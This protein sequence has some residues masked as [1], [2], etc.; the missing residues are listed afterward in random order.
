[1]NPFKYSLSVSQLSHVLGA[2]QLFAWGSL[3]YSFPLIAIAMEN[4]LGWSKSEIYMGASLGML[5]SSA[6]AYPIGLAID[7]GFGRWI[8]TIA[9]F[10]AALMLLIWSTVST[11][12]GF[13]AIS[14]V[15]GAL[16]ACTLY[17]AAFAVISNVAQREHSRSHITVITLW[18]GFASSVLI[19]LEQFFIN[20]IGWRS[21]LSCLGLMNIGW[22]II[23]FYTLKNVSNDS[24]I[25]NDPSELSRKIENQEAVKKAI[26]SSV[27]WLILTALTL[28]SVMFTV[29]IFHAFPILQEKGLSSTDAVKVLMVLG[30]IQVLGRLLLSYFAAKVPIRLIGSIFALFFPLIFIAMFYLK[31]SNFYFLLFLVGCYGLSNGIFTIVRSLVV[32]EM[33]S[34]NAYGAINGL[35]TI[36]TMIARAVGP[37]V[38]ASLWMIH[39]SY[40][41]VLILVIVVS[42]IFMI[43]FWTAS[44]IFS[45]TD[46]NLA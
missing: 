36:P 11:L 8:L 29:F 23:Y 30:P 26:R 18:G 27:F 31:T 20:E 37:G 38:A 10:F 25:K 32:P 45:Q 4:D 19:P 17:E 5:V 16:Q 3:Y 6:L 41:D 44:W 40:Q 46:N 22:A 14:I 7:N 34:R 33:L 12:V 21:S 9:S 2:G 1:M 43:A 35:L 24:K 28:Y 39:Q 15:I 42:T 13:Y